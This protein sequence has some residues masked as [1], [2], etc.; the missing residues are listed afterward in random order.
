MG[1]LITKV[2]ELSLLFLAVI[3]VMAITG[4]LLINPSFE[5]PSVLGEI[6]CLSSGYCQTNDDCCSGKCISRPIINRIPFL[7][8]KGY[9]GTCHPSTAVPQPTKYLPKPTATARATPKNCPDCQTLQRNLQTMLDNISC[10][11]FTDD[12]NG[13]LDKV[14]YY[15]ANGQLEPVHTT[16]TSTN[17]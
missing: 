9:V 13:L 14:N 4:V 11:P 6:S 3:M 1:K 16:S 8:S 12:L 15:C 10:V 2:Q 17:Q 5:Q 7:R